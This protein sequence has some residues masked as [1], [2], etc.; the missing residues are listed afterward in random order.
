MVCC[1]EEEISFFP[2]RF[3]LFRF[4]WYLKRLFFYH[5]FFGIELICRFCCLSPRGFVFVE[6]FYLVLPCI[7]ID[8][9]SSVCVCAEIGVDIKVV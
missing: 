4:S 6:G 1:V 7:E 2:R 5:I 8:I 3:V 9:Y